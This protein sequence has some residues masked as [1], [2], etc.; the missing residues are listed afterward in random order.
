VLGRK[1]SGVLGAALLGGAVWIGARATGTVPPLGALLDPVHGVWALASHAELP[2]AARA[3]IPSLRD[4]VDVRYDDRGVPHIFA[5]NELD[6]LRALGYVVARD[7]LF[8]LELQT[9]AAAGTLTEL[10]GDRALDAD[11][12]AR[13]IGLPWG[14]QRKFAAVKPGAPTM[15]AMEAYA[16]GVNAYIDHMSAGDLPLEYRLLNR[17]PQRWRP[18]HTMLLL[19]RMGYTLAWSGFELDRTRIEARIGRA[20][21]DAL[22]P[23]D[24]YIQEPIQ[25]NGQRS[26]RVDAAHVPPPHPDTAAAALAKVLAVL[27]R[28]SADPSEA[29]VGSN[30]WAVAPGRSANGHALLANDPHLDLSLPSTWYE[31]HLV[32]PD[33]LDAYG[34][35]F[36]GAP[37]IALG[38]NRDVAWGSTNVGA[39]VTDYYIE[40]VN[41]ARAP[42]DYMVDGQWR[43]LTRSIEEYRGPRGELIATDTIRYTHRGPMTRAGEKW[44]SQRW[45]VLEPTA[46]F[47][48]FRLA[49]HAHSIREFFDAMSLFESPAQNFI[50]ADRAGHIGV[51]S[52]GRYPVRPGDGRGDRLFDGSKSANDWTQWIVSSAAPQSQDPPQGYLAS[53][54]QEPADPR[55]YPAYLGNEWPS[56]WRAMQI[57]TLLR[58]D[59]AVT[60]DAM[61]RFQTDPASA[62]ANLFVPL[63]LA[64]AASELGAGRGDAEL[65]RAAALLG[66]WDRRFTPENH[67]AVLF[68]AAM[69]ELA[70][71]TWDEL[72]EDSANTNVPANRRVA[73]PNEHVLYALTLDPDNVWWDRRATPLRETRDAILA[74]ALGA[75]LARTETLRGPA[76]GDKWTWS[77]VRFANIWHPLHLAALSAL[78]LPMQGGVETLSPSS[79]DGTHG[80]SW[81]LVADLGTPVKAWGIYPGGQSANPVSSHYRDHIETWRRGALDSLRIPA[82]AQALHA[83]HLAATLVLTPRR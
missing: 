7:R 26:A 76:T 40:T 57:N 46:D 32:V 61:R 20:A 43:H 11:R 54:N 27:G 67:R 80:A 31:A 60:P 74:T 16:D 71:Y 18:E 75:A 23:R 33:S 37:S 15:R 51:R 65:K 34:V 36:P 21:T 69:R 19:V 78:E 24:A 82:T 56:P 8:Q 9:R 12:E 45:M 83:E 79:G 59:S 10:V 48:A 1:V 77:R 81:R 41:D 14:A 73:T 39:D 5:T 2:R 68:E 13:E 6:A 28:S 17:S 50:A 66:E 38:L 35:T 47:E 70:R 58:A 4:S 63:F 53:A 22:F 52:T 64:A 55:V 49:P 44:I 30:S 29:V 25:P 3:A 72:A 42:V 62:R